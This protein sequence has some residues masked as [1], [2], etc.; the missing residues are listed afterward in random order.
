ML[1][2]LFINV[3]SKSV[4]QS[5]LSA[6]QIAQTQIAFIKD[7]NEIWTQ[8]HYYDCNDTKYSTEQLNDIIAQYLNTHDVTDVATWATKDNNETIPE[9]KLPNKL[10]ITGSYN[11]NTGKFISGGQEVTGVAGNLYVDAATGKLYRYSSDTSSF[12]TV[13]GETVDLTNYIQKSE[14]SGL[15]KNDGTIDTN[16]YLTS[17]DI[18]DKVDANTVYT[19]AEIDSKIG[20]LGNTS[21]E[22]P[23]SVKSYVDEQINTLVGGAPDT[24]DTLKEI[25][26]VL[27]N[28]ETGIGAINEALASKANVTD[29]KQSDWN[30][31]TNTELDYIK[32]KPT[33]TASFTNVGEGNTL[34]N[35]EEY[36]KYVLT[37]QLNSVR[38]M[39]N[40]I[41]NDPV[42]IDLH[43]EEEQYTYYFT[44]QTTK[45]DITNYKNMLNTNTVPS[46]IEVPTGAKLYALIPSSNNVSLEIVG[47]SDS[48]FIPLANN[49]DWTED[50]LYKLVYTGVNE[51]AAINLKVTIS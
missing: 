16:S 30:Q 44:A 24:L 32:N 51:G 1:N 43:S 34:E 50:E 13:G 7:S 35:S 14:T 15:I 37:S 33:T 12:V 21:S 39:V 5:L 25:A 18:S 41:I 23:H 2:G 36:D 38:A 26:D 28:N 6:G 46:S 11:S 4:F 45:P 8:G 48:P 49:E 9:N 3:S 40:S 42:W 47:D 27:N 19:K 17:A 20:N 29:L 22:T 31:T 10:I